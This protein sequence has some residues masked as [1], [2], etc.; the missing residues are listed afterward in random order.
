MK[1]KTFIKKLILLFV[2]KKHIT[3]KVYYLSPN[4]KLKGKKILI[5][6]GGRGL[7]SAMAEK[8]TK[9]GASVLIC[10]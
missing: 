3:A 8:F 6:G 1:L 5:T 10:G 7:G 9:E 4:E 2:P